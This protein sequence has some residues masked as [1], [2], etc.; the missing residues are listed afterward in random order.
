[1]RARRLLTSPPPLRLG[2]RRARHGASPML[3]KGVH[4]LH[5][6]GVQEGVQ[7]CRFVRGSRWARNPMVAPSQFPPATNLNVQ[8]MNV[9]RLRVPERSGALRRVRR[10]S[11]AEA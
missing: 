4:D 10:C 1:M 8:L 2:T 5:P 11:A 9:A 6:R 7:Q 3:T